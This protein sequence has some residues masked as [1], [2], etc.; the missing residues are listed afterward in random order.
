MGTGAEKSVQ[1]ARGIWSWPPSGAAVPVGLE[2]RHAGELTI[3]KVAYGDGLDRGQRGDGLP[4]GKGLT[5]LLALTQGEC[6]F[7]ACD[8]RLR[9]MRP[10][11]V[12]VLDSG[13]LD[14]RPEAGALLAGLA[15]PSHLLTPR[16]LGSDRLKA[17][18]LQS[19]GLGMA[20]LLYD[21][22]AK[23]AARETATPGAGALVDAVGGLLSAVLE[24]CLPAARPARGEAGQARLDQIHRY[25]TRHFADP[26]LS[27]ADAAA[28]VGVSRRYLHRLYAH[29]DQSFRDE[30]IG[31]RIEACVKAFRDP[32]QADRTIAEIA[33]GAGYTD[34]SQFNR[35]F[36]RLTGATPSDLRRAALPADKRLAAERRRLERAA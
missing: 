29:Y 16:F 34:I 11:E 24:D 19:H 2:T 8:E 15:V 33:F 1:G 36:R 25:L 30:L 22:L 12:L 7:R 3:I 5:L 10:G 6:A 21:L 20:S 26:D 31:L 4:A 13:A 32:A 27:A 18:S 35:H 9:P 23:L 28:A 14:L 17:G